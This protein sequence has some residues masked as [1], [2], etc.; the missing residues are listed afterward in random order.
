MVTTSSPHTPAQPAPPQFGLDILAPA[1]LR[2][3]AR[4]ARDWLRRGIRRSDA[5]GTELRRIDPLV[6]QA[7]ATG[8][9]AVPTHHRWCVIWP[10][11]WMGSADWNPW[12]KAGC[13]CPGAMLT[14]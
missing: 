13:C 8:T 12:R 3:L 6:D 10:R 4:L 5:I 1:A 14:P 2:I 9:P 7:R 11:R